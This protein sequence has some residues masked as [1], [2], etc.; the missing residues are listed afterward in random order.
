MRVHDSQA[1]RKMDVTREHHQR[2]YLHE[3]KIKRLNYTHDGPAEQSYHDG[4]Y[5]LVERT[6]RKENVEGYLEHRNIARYQTDSE[7]LQ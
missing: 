1:Y 5:K 7:L 4:R 2:A 3:K 6:C